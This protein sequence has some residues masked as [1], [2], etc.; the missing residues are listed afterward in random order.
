MNPIA[1]KVH[2]DAGVAGACPHHAPVAEVDRF[3]RV[4]E[5]NTPVDALF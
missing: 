3:A 1:V 4:R 5:N 2:A